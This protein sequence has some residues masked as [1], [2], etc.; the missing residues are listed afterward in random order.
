MTN[1]KKE[2][3]RYDTEMGN[4]TVYGLGHAL[5]NCPILKIHRMQ[6][7]DMLTVDIS[8]HNLNKPQISAWNGKAALFRWRVTENSPET[9]KVK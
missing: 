8:H 5:K 1:Y 7:C 9:K 3:V 6:K 2:P 4:V